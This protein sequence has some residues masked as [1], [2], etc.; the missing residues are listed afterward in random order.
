MR[1]TLTLLLLLPVISAAPQ[2]TRPN[3]LLIFTDDQSWKTL[4]C[5]RDEGAW[6]WVR[7]PQIDRLAEEGVRFTHAYGAAWCI[8]SRASLLTGLLPHGIEGFTVP[9]GFRPGNIDP[10]VCRFWPRE[11]RKAGYE[12]AVV[13]KWH[14]GRDSGHGLDWD[15]SVVWD[16]FSPRG[17]WYNGQFYRIDGAPGKKVPGYATDLM[18]QFAEKYIRRRHGKPWFLK[19]SYN[20]PH[21]PNTYS[22]RHEGRYRNAPVKMPP[23][24]FGPRPEKPRYMRTRTR[25]KP[26]EGSGAESLVFIG[27]PYRKDGLRLPR[28]VRDYNR[29]ICAIDEGVGRLTRALEETGQLGRTLIVFTSDQGF[30]W[31]EHGFSDKTAPYEACMRMPFIVRWP[32]VATRG[33]VCRRPA[34]VIDLAPT[35]FAA[36]GAPL[37]WPMHGRD[38]A[39]LLRDPDAE[40]D[41]PVLV[42]HF[43]KTFG[44]G[45]RKGR[46]GD[47]DHEGIPWWISLRRG[48]YKY[49]RTL[50]EDEIEEL[51]DLESDPDELKN[52]AV[53]PAR[54]KLLED[55]RAL[56]VAELRRTGAALVENLPAPRVAR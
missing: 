13:G 47:D 22:P 9:E 48:K 52:L 49:I 12:T 19:L 33:A 39:P 40:W 34:S 38:I 42:E 20:A 29:L 28:L 30:A 10:D 11:L 56:L 50:V 15:R 27:W 51:Y 8:P 25:F 37:P 46:T 26:G 4:G 18:T 17:D 32:G 24:V 21:L 3:I 5:Y 45:T 2:E 14:L 16:Q 53:D 43:F 7:T 41:R 6:P 36:A 1:P 44:S 55:H 54:R 31:G 35:F 23:G